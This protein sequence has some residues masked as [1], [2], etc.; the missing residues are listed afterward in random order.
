MLLP[1]ALSVA[2]ADGADCSMVQA[3]RLSVAAGPAG[4]RALCYQRLKPD[5]S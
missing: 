2:G 3:R 5:L 1:E 4:L